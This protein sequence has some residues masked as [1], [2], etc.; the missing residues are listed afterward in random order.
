MHLW[1]GKVWEQWKMVVRDGQRQRAA[2]AERKEK[3]FL[4]KQLFKSL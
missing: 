1:E 3:A 2:E 4:L